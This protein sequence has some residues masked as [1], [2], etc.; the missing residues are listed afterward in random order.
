MVVRWAILK[1][2]CTA[3]S[4]RRGPPG[5]R[6]LPETETTN[7][8]PRTTLHEP[9]CPGSFG[10]AQ[11]AGFWY[12]NPQMR[13][14]ILDTCKE[15]FDTFVVAISV[16]MAFRAYFYEPFNIPTGSM[17]PTLYGNHTVVAK[18]SDATVWDKG[19]LKLLKWAWT[20]DWFKT[21]EAPASGTLM[22]QPNQNN[23]CIRLFVSTL[24]GKTYDI[25]TDAFGRGADGTPYLPNG[26]RPGSHVRA[27]ELLWCGT[28]K[29]GDFL[30][31]NRWIWNFRHPRRGEVMIFATT[32]L[33]GVQQGTHYIKRMAGLPGETLTMDPPRLVVNG[34][35]VPEEG[36]LG[37]IMRREKFS[38]DAFPYPG[39]NFSGTDDP[40]FDVP[41][42]TLAK[43]GDE[44]M[45][46]PDEYYACGDNSPASYDS[47][48]WGPVPGKL[49]R[50]RAGGVF[51][52]FGSP[53]W[54]IIR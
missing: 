28:V 10:I 29:S 17:M 2:T 9:S 40:R 41:G 30:F 7:H 24:P 31:V 20:G 3:P 33:D 15:W 43:A 36:R 23:G 14:S 4:N 39:F 27:G 35:P 6:P 45:L 44:V 1:T 21:V 11:G 51:W 5:G 34:E 38:P 54:G 46:G 37:Q 26:L 18:P 53:R 42:R 25:P 8:A 13:K 19:P 48:W 49:L 22:M 32:G 47:R 52:P 16:A 50:G 12:N